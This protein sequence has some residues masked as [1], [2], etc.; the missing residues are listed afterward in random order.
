MA[1]IVDIAGIGEK[2]SQKLGSIGINSTEELIS[3]INSQ[4][5]LDHVASVAGVS[6]EKVARWLNMADL[7]R[8]DNMTEGWSL[9]LNK[10]GV[11]NTQ[12]LKGMN[13]ASLLQS[14][15][16]VINNLDHGF[17]TELPPLEVVRDWVSQ[18][19]NLKTIGGLALGLGSLGAGM[20]M[21]GAN[22]GGKVT[23]AVTGAANM[24]EGAMGV[25]G[26]MA[27][28]VVDGVGNV[29]GASMNAAGNV[30][31][32][33]MGVAG[34][35][36][37]G[38]VGMAGDAAR[39]IWRWLLPLLLLLLLGLLLLWG[40]RTDWWGIVD[41]AKDTVSNV[42][43]IDVELPDVDI[44]TPDLDLE[45]DTPDINLPDFDISGLFGRF[46]SLSGFGSMMSLPNVSSA[47]DFNNSDY[48][49][50]APSDASLNALGINFADLDADVQLDYLNKVAVDGQVGL[51]DL[52]DGYSLTTLS[53]DT[54]NFTVDE[55]G[56]KLVNGVPFEINAS[57]DGDRTVLFTTQ[58]PLFDSFLTDAVAEM[59]SEVEADMMSNSYK[60]LLS[61]VNAN[62][63]LSMCVMMIEA[64]SLSTMMK[65]GEEYTFFLPTDKALMN[66]GITDMGTYLE[67]KT[68]LEIDTIMNN[69]MITG[70]TLTLDN[71][72]LGSNIDLDGGNSIK[73]TFDQE[74]T[75]QWHHINGNFKKHI[76]V[77]G[78]TSN[79]VT[80]HVTD[81][82]L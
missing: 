66:A 62:S 82:M 18:S 52:I 29:A 45:I 9:L 48:S 41:E 50:F 17:K 51:S 16:G 79:G 38:A 26:D 28:G 78:T 27:G 4:E 35:V 47:F 58:K 12:Q 46:P 63:D 13:P 37:S 67:G 5:S 22:V 44:D 21:A 60:E 81:T 14:M 40:W 19:M 39:S 23:G 72:T 3:S 75:G 8:L 33:S 49:F 57:D 25:A 70:E 20:K 61:Q 64:S 65:D 74:A 11:D 76:N 36:A 54:L 15:T 73:V 10:I 1:D 59:K 55:N 31:S 6:Q 68:T 24:A 32:D 43:E 2:I 34:G 53:G 30:I 71:Y 7:F 69:H 56:E 80:L 77:W 42:T